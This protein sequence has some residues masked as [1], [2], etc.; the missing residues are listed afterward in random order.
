[1]KSNAK[2]FL[3][4]GMLRNNIVHRNFASFSLEKS[5]EEIIELYRKGNNFIRFIESLLSEYQT[6]T[7]TPGDES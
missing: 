1:M 2:A 5:F 7:E 3:E 4:L 6:I